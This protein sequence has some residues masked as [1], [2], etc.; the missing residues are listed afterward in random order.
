M[1]SFRHR[2]LAPLWNHN[3]AIGVRADLVERVRVRLLLIHAAGAPREA[4]IPGF[5]VG[6]AGGDPP[7]YAMHV[8]GDVFLTYGWMGEDAVEVDLERSAREGV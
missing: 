1:R 2:G 8:K 4:A 3:I 6:D 5:H 7:R